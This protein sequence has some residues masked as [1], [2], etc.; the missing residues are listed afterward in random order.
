[1]GQSADRFDQYDHRHH[2]R[3]HFIHWLI[4]VLGGATAALSSAWFLSEDADA[5]PYMFPYVPSAQRQKPS[6]D[7]PEGMEINENPPN[8]N[9][10][11]NVP[12]ERAYAINWYQPRGL[13]MPS[14]P[15]AIRDENGRP[16]IPFNDQDA[17]FRY[18]CYL[19]WE[20]NKSSRNPPGTFD[21]IGDMALR[22]LNI[23]CGIGVSTSYVQSFWAR[24][25]DAAIGYYTS[26]YA[27]P[28]DHPYTTDGFALLIENRSDDARRR[29]GGF[30]VQHDIAI[31][32]KQHP[33][34]AISIH[35]V[36]LFFFS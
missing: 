32:P 21:D 24:N 30:I 5:A 2:H 22:L 14:I 16:I 27:K 1:M 9:I 4:Y 36:I 11:N 26:G 28:Y 7:L 6:D 18:L 12:F 34:Y 15:G 25:Y 17:A 13:Y 10:I 31:L 35:S 19:E 29:N 23:N 33:A 20:G 8:E 3:Q